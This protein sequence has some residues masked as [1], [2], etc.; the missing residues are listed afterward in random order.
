MGDNG[1][2]TRRSGKAL[3]V[4]GASTVDDAAV[5][6]RRGCRGALGRGSSSAPI[7]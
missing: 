4:Q 6:Q 2:D 7:G 3:E 5:V 1:V